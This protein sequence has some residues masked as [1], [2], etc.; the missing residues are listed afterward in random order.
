[1]GIDWTERT[2]LP[3]DEGLILFECSA[4]FHERQLN[5]GLERRD[6]LPHKNESLPTGLSDFHRVAL[7]ATDAQRPE[8]GEHV[9]GMTDRGN[10]DCYW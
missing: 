4:K 6:C 8:P 1:M 9:G 3:C 10:V 2:L 7:F 5:A